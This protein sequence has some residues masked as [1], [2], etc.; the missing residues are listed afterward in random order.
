MYAATHRSSTHVSEDRRRRGEKSVNRTARDPSSAIPRIKPEFEEV[1]RMSLLSPIPQYGTDQRPL[2]G[3]RRKSPRTKRRQKKLERRR[4]RLKRKIDVDQN[5]AN[6]CVEVQVKV[7][8]E[9]E[10][11]RSRMIEARRVVRAL[12]SEIKDKE[13]ALLELMLSHHENFKTIMENQGILAE[14]HSIGWLKTTVMMRK[15][16]ALGRKSP[17]QAV[18]DLSADML[19]CQCN[20]VWEKGLEF[21][22]FVART[23][24]V[25]LFDT[26]I[27]KGICMLINNS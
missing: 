1:D 17:G 3:V 15:S 19:V 16:R 21:G 10:H 27:F 9:L 18:Y 24:A 23:P 8:G 14:I 2:R 6:A 5:A 4:R 20:R 25:D 26:S 13:T 11:A 12:N 7:R 22:I